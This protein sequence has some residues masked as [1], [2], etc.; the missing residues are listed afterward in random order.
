M[1]LLD[2]LK[3][4][5]RPLR[6]TILGYVVGIILSTYIV[7]AVELIH[8]LVIDHSWAVGIFCFVVPSM[9]GVLANVLWAWRHGRAELLKAP[10]AEHVPGESLW[11]R[12]SW[13]T[14]LVVMFGVWSGGYYLIAHLT[15]RREMHSLALDLDHAIPFRPVWVWPYLSVFSLYLVPLLVAK[16]RKLIN[17]VITSYLTLLLVCYAVFWFYPV[18][19]PRPIIFGSSLTDWTLGLVYNNDRP[20]NCFPSSHCAIALMAALILLEVKPL[21]GA[22]GMFLA[23]MVGAST[24]FTKQHFLVDV[25]AGFLVAFLV[26]YVCFKQPLIDL[27][28]KKQRELTATLETALTS[29]LNARIE[30]YVHKILIE[31][32]GLAPI[33][34]GSEKK[35]PDHTDAEQ[36]RSGTP[37]PP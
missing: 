29:R 12:F 20:W 31:E 27:L 4:V 5:Q 2:Q 34:H 17:L 7:F 33:S 35:T 19:C 15:G 30:A 1:S 25:L 22:V 6:L 26:Y 28:G 23:L 3:R 21:Y 8:P 36:P 16:D 14:R 11:R 10:H 32:Y 24:L 18:L 9:V 37:R 13:L